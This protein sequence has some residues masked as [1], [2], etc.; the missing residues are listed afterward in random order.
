[1][2]EPQTREWDMI[3]MV[4][5]S[6]CLKKYLWVKSGENPE[7]IYNDPLKKRYMGVD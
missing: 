6:V 2:L 5:F 7:E 3:E 1:M 4:Y